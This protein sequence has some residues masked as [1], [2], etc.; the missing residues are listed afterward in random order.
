MFPEERSDAA[1][2]HVVNSACAVQSAAPR[3]FGFAMSRR[4]NSTNDPY[5]ARDHNRFGDCLNFLGRLDEARQQHEEALAIYQRLAAN[6]SA[7][8]SGKLGMAKSRQKLGDVL[9]ELGRTPEAVTNFQAGLQL[10]EALLGVDASNADAKALRLTCR[11]KL[12][13]E[14]AEVVVH[15]ILPES[16]ALEIG[17]KAGD[18]LVSYDG[19][20]VVCSSDLPLLTARAAGTSIELD[21]RREGASLKL[22]VKAGPLG[23][24]C[25]DR[26]VVNEH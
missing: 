9:V 15:E 20:P 14:K 7:E 4:L 12:G 1:E 25:E 3:T 8:I 26:S 17:L 2:W 13:L 21:I 18:V 10:A 23:L 11:I 19:T 6:P 22:A 16:Q 24:V 5:F